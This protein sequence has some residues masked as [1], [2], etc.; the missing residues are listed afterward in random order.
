MKRVGD[1]AGPG[2]MAGQARR[3][4][5]G[6]GMD[7]PATVFGE[8]GLV[9]RQEAFRMAT[10]RGVRS[11]AECSRRLRAGCAVRQKAAVVVAF[12][13][14]MLVGSIGQAEAQIDP[15]I[16]SD[17]LDA[18]IQNMTSYGAMQ[19]TIEDT[20]GHDGDAYLRDL[21]PSS[22]R[23][24]S[25]DGPD[26]SIGR[27]PSV[28]REA[29][30]AFIESIRRA[31]GGRVADLIDASFD[32]KSVYAG[33][34]EIAGPYGLRADDYGDVFAAYMVTMWMVANQAPP[35]PDDLV[36][37]VND[38]AHWVLGRGSLQ[39][40]RRERQRVA[41]TMMYELVSA[42][43]GRQEAERVGDVE[44]LD[45]MATLARRKFLRS[46]LDLT[47]TTLGSDGMVSR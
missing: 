6:S 21:D 2:R 37:S 7:L 47:A 38:Q 10:S 8:R 39:G 12:A 40:S 3:R 24:E 28:S 19:T 43:Y 31:N 22:R 41:E 46:G 14:A 30:R 20:R 11:G 15:T 18:T 44:T 1:G 5:I 34:R 25:Y 42:I 36:R 27:D 13:I 32:Q 9:R 23:D 29:R 33:F 4:C 35:P 45:R 16:G 26:F 17:M